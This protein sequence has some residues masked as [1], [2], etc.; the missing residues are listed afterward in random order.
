MCRRDLRS[1]CHGCDVPVGDHPPLADRD[2]RV[3]DRRRVGRRCERADVRDPRPRNRRAARD[4]RRGRGA[5]HR[6]GRPGCTPRA[7]GRAVVAHVAFRARPDHPP[8]RRRDHGARRRAGRARQP[9]QRQAQDRR[10]RRRRPAGRRHLLVHVGLGLEDP[11]RHDHAVGPVHAGR[12]VSL[13][14]E[15]GAGRRRRPDHPVELPVAHGRVEARPC[16][17]DRLHRRAQAR[18]ADAAVGAA[19]GRAHARGRPAGGRRQR[20]CR[21]RRDR[22]RGARRARRRGQDRVHRLDRGRQ[23]HRARRDGQ[24]QAR[25]ARARRQV[26]EHHPVRCRRRRRDRRRRA[27]DLLQPG[28]GVQRGQPP[29]RPARPVRPR[30]RG[31]LAGRA[32]D[33]G[34]SRAGSRHGDGPARLRG[35]V[36]PGDRLPR[37]RAARRAAAR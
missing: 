12:R 9:R 28:R 6:P 24:P 15:Q 26:A 17:R 32:G 19:A 13:L 36:R 25:L 16:A 7:R 1:P 20:R 27:G 35:A 33:Q 14:H 34:R 10:A 4:R 30:G 18:R 2:P 29:V 23:A 31:R 3:A 37:A 5:R 21:V 22:R 11:G 8:H